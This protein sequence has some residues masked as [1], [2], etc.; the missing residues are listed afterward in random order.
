VRIVWQLA[1]QGL[2][3]ELEDEMGQVNG[4]EI[5]QESATEGLRTAFLGVSPFC[6]TCEDD[7]DEQARAAGMSMVEGQG[8]AVVDRC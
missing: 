7:A 1:K 3:E 4:G 5:K 2:S 6:Q 8:S